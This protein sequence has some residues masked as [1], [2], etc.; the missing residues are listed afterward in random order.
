LDN[1]F[2]GDSIHAIVQSEVAIS[3]MSLTGRPALRAAVVPPIEAST[4]RGDETTL[5]RSA[6]SLGS[7]RFGGNGV[8]RFDGAVAS[9]RLLIG[10]GP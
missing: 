4:R 9:V 7:K 3:A 10:L 8:R 6:T 2:D 5:S 1:H